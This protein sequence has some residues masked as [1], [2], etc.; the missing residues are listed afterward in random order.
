MGF[1]TFLAQSP[2]LF[3]LVLA[4][5]PRGSSI[6]LWPGSAVMKVASCTTPS[7]TFN[8]LESSCRCSSSH[9]LSSLPVSINRSLKAQTVERS[10]II[11]GNPKKFLKDIRSLDCLSSSGSDNPY[12]CCKTNILNITIS[13]LLGLHH[14]LFHYHTYYELLT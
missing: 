10:G 2:S 11:S 8:P 12:H 4:S 14:V 9:I 3:R 7:F 1:S 6:F 5:G 13:S